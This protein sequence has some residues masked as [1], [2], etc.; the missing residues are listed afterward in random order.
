MWSDNC[1]VVVV[2]VV[3]V[4]VWLLLQYFGRS[5]RCRCRCCFPIALIVIAISG[6][7]SGAV[8]AAVAVVVRRIKQPFRRDLERTTAYSVAVVGAASI[9]SSVNISSSSWSIIITAAAAR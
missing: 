2:V 9:S 6:S 1:F 3:I 7:P 5:L 8:A 4:N